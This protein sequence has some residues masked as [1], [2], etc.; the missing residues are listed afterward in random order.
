[1]SEVEK[2]K[3]YEIKTG[4]SPIC[5][6]TDWNVTEPQCDKSGV[7]VRTLQEALDNPVGSL[8]LEELTQEAKH[9][10]VVLPDATRSWQYIP[11]M[12]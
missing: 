12:V 11:L 5:W 3:Q 4:V 1:M 7:W 2:M 9:P 8:H 10:V 6:N